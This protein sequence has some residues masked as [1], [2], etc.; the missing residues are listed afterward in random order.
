[1]TQLVKRAPRLNKKNLTTKC[2]A[3][4]TPGDNNLFHNKTYDCRCVHDAL[5]W[6]F[7]LF[8]NGGIFSGSSDCELLGWPTEKPTEK[9]EPSMDPHAHLRGPSGGSHPAKGGG[10]CVRWCDLLRALHQAGE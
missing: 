5:L 1:M 4:S 7:F 2:L 6:G 8:Q 9:Y 10:R 3:S